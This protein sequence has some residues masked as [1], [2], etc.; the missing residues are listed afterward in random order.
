MLA[1]LS[2]LSAAIFLQDAQEERLRRLEEEVKRHRAAIE[3][4]K[5]G[6]DLELSATDGLLLRTGDGR[7]EVALGGRFIEHVRTTFDR[8]DSPRTSQ[9]T[10]LVRE[11]FVELEATVDR[12]FGITIHGDLSSSAGGPVS[13]LEIAVL[14]W[15]RFEE[16]RL[17]LGQFRT[18]NSMESMTSTLFTDC[19]ERSVLSRFVPELEIGAMAAGDLWERR[20]GYQL[21]LTNGRAHLAGAGRTTNDDTDEKEL[22]ARVTASPFEG[23]D[24]AF[25]HLRLGIY[26]SAGSADDL[27]MATGFDF[28]TTELE[29]VVFDS[30]AG[31][32]DGRRTRL[33]A[34][35]SWAAG[36]ASLRAELLAREDEV[37][38]A[39]GAIRE[40]LP[41]RAGYVQIT[42]IL[43]GAEKAVE[44]RLTPAHPLD[45]A[46]G[47]WGALELVL[48][49]AGARI[50][51]SEFEAVGNSALGQSNEVRTWTVGLNWYPV[52]NVRLSADLV[53]EDYRDRIDFGGGRRE[54]VL[55][56]LLLR[57]QI[58]L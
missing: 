21:A 19:A 34:E 13:S 53:R 57:F 28:A 12:E 41:V 27:P 39:T 8:P 55:T 2:L 11:V 51:R 31:F 26:A 56:G 18:P 5:E 44:T 29:V 38:D 20:L 36:P 9:D 42:S 49:A 22:L 10:F 14:E 3:R 30:T 25:R 46:R 52:L 33:G 48:R 15:K 54:D 45:P 32:L 58:D 7:L 4:L 1:V 6:P 50:G 16:F 24:S 23:E 40:D 43:F 35:L 47:D 37:R 17:L